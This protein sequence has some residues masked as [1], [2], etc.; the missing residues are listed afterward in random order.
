MFADIKREID[1][2]VIHRI[3]GYAAFDDSPEGIAK[4]VRKYQSNPNLHFYGWCE[5]GKPLGICGYEVHNDKVE[6]HL[7]SVDENARG[8]GIGGAMVTAL[9]EKYKK[10]IEAETDDSAVEFYRKCGFEMTE[11]IHE[12][13]GKRYTCLK[14][15]LEN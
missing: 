13:R 10:D 8:R 3:I 1:N 4:T 9:Q 14:K 12:T 7:I 5:N 11:L 2:P 6:I 15:Y